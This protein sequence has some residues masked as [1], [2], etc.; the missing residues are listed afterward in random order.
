MPR[1]YTIISIHELAF[2]LCPSSVPLPF[3][4]AR[5]AAQLLI[6]LVA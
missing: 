4:L 6:G 3:P 5:G 1:F 2:Y